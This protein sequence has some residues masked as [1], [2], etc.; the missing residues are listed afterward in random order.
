MRFAAFDTLS[1]ICGARS[2]TRVATPALGRLRQTPG[3]N[4]RH[5]MGSV[6]NLIGIHYCLL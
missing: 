6:F 1:I 3:R 5:A 4:V 2:A